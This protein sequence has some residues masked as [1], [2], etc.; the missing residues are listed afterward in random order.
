MF[1]PIP[2][3][4]W[5]PAS[6]LTARSLQIGFICWLLA[7][8]NRSAEFELALDDSVKFGLSRFSASRGLFTLEW[9]GLARDEIF[10]YGPLHRSRDDQLCLAVERLKSRASRGEIQ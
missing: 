10:D 3:S 5:L 9:V 6:A 7:G 2:R 4:W 1:G 8:W